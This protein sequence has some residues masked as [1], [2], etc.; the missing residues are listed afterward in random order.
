MKETIYI[1]IDPGVSG[2]IAMIQGNELEFFKTPE[3][4]KGVLTMFDDIIDESNEIYCCMEDVHSMPMDGAKG[5]FRFGYIVGITQSA[6]IYS[7]ISFDKVSP[8]RW[9]AFMNCK[10]PQIK[11]IESQ[12]ERKGRLY[13]RAQQLFPN[14]K[15]PKYA[16][17][18]VLIAEYC[19]RIKTGKL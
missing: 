10:K 5:A 17:D 1:G 7:G 16:A 4:L 14:N 2:A 12:T 19:R 8:Q 3:T 9:Q 18:A 11:K 13:N 6:L 15:F